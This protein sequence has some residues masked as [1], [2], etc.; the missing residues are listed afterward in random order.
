MTVMHVLARFRIA[1]KLLMA[2]V[3]AVLL[4]LTV[5]VA[6]WQGLRQQQASIHTVVDLRTP[7]LL[8]TVELS[9]QLLR[10]REETYRLLA[11]SNANFSEEQQKKLAVDIQRHLEALTRSVAAMTPADDATD[12]EK[13]LVPSLADKVANFG[14]AIRNAAEIADADQSVATTMMIKSEPPYRQLMADIEQLR[15]TQSRRSR[16]AVDRADQAYQQALAA[17]GIAVALALLLTSLIGWAVRRDVLRSVAAIRQVAD[18]L[19]AGDLSPLA[20]PA[21]QDELATSAQEL[22]QTVET[23]RDSMGRVLNASANIDV[24]TN[25]IAQGYD[26]LATRT[27]TQAGELQQASANMSRL[28]GTVEDNAADSGRASTLAAESFKAADQGRSVVGEVVIGMRQ[29]ADSAKQI[30]EITAVIDGIAFQ[31]NILALN[32]AVE[33]ARAGEHGR[34]FAVVA[35]EVRSLSQRSATAAGDIRRLI[36][37]SVERIES[38]A[39]LA[40][41]A[42]Q[43]MGRI[44]QTADGL[45]QAVGRI[46]ASIADQHAGIQ[47]MSGTVQT[48]DTGTQQNAALVEQAAAAAESLSQESRRL[49]QTVSR[50]NVAA[51]P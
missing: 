29:I 4:A 39:V 33:A 26:D 23:L 7:Q 1:T 3:A 49:V 42:G 50:F 31:T 32:A 15:Q 25:E 18:R 27:E 51:T 40:E 17:S 12:Q 30:S 21:G 37:S 6:G 45:A 19:R 13:Q 41:Q 2:P 28:L 5:G 11:W 47:S 16:E 36:S 14:K 8:Q 20:P 22:V 46:T 24:A 43:V 10:V 9:E 35:A 48:V 44:V 38:G 34:G